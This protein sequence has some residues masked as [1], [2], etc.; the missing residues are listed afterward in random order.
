MGGPRVRSPVLSHHGRCE[1]APR[2]ATPVSFSQDE[3]VKVRKEEEEEEEEE[4]EEEEER[5]RDTMSNMK[6]TGRVF[7]R[8]LVPVHLSSFPL[9][10]C[11][12]PHGSRFITI[13]AG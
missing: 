1:R 13:A 11:S 8:L 12:D 6:L 4:G 3:R 5:T 7:S 10:A 2:C 9:L